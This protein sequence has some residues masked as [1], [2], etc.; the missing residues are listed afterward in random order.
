MSNEEQNVH[1]L[2]ILNRKK[3]KLTGVI[4]VDSFDDDQVELATKLGRLVI[5]GQKL[6]VNQ[7]DV[8]EG[9]LTIEGIVTGFQYYE[10][11]KGAKAKSK[12]I[13]ERLLK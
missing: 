11:G 8:A 12:G 5:K 2:S 7:L 1:T 9:N 3:I 13:L 10:E 6:H 4:Q